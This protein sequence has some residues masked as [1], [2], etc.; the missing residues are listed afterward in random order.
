MVVAALL[1]ANEVALDSRSPP[2]GSPNK[3]LRPCLL[4]YSTQVCSVPSFETHHLERW[5]V[6]TAG[7]EDV[8]DETLLKMPDPLLY[9]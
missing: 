9:R 8:V 7:E 1:R 2:H 5:H 6:R 3:L 4:Y